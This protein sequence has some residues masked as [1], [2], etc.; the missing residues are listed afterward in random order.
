M[1]L[2]PRWRTLL[3]SQ[4]AI[5]YEMATALA[6]FVSEITCELMMIISPVLLCR[7]PMAGRQV[8]LHRKSLRRTLN[9]GSLFW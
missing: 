6:E 7:S 4:R 5:D 2:W 1:T 9:D 3:P 8:G